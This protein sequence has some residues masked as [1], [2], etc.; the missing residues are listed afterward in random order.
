MSTMMETSNDHSQSLNPTFSPSWFGLLIDIC[1]YL[2]LDLFRFHLKRHVLILL[3]MFSVLWAIVILMTLGA[4]LFS[5]IGP[6]VVFS[7][8]SQMISGFLVSW[9]APD[10]PASHQLIHK[11]TNVGNMHAV[12][13]DSVFAH[14][15]IYVWFVHISQN[16][17][18]QS[19]WFTE[20]LF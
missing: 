15:D 11:A 13:L 12:L 20:T 7:P 9:M 8:L 16:A 3:L 6:A 19:K 14:E 4:T 1:V 10:G 18:I 17:E 2:V 5:H